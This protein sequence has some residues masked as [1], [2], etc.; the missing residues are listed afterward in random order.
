MFLALVKLIA[1]VFVAA[2]AGFH[3]EDRCFTNRMMVRVLLSPDRSATAAT[4]IPSAGQ[5]N[6]TDKPK[7]RLAGEVVTVLTPSEQ[8]QN[9]GTLT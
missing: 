9:K 8:G 2:S 6:H 4:G 5:E 7:E 1:T 3:R